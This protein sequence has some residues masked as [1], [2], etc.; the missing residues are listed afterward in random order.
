M[1]SPI[2]II[3]PTLVDQ[4]GH[5]HS[6]VGAVCAAG[7]EQ[8]LVVWAGRRASEV[9]TGLPHVT[10]R[11]HF[12]RR[13]RRVQAFLLYRKLLRQGARIF[14]P[15][16]GV[17]DIAL[18]CRAAPRRLAPGAAVAFCH[19]IRPT[20]RRKQRL[21]AAARRQPDL[22]VLAGADEIVAMLHDAGFHR[23]AYA[24]YP[25]TQ[26]APPLASAVPFRHLLFA[27]AARMDK[28]FPHIVD[29]A[30]H[31]A[32]TAESVP[33][34]VQTSA[35]HYGKLAP[36]IAAELLRLE[37]AAYRGLVTHPDTL[38]TDGYF[39]LFRGAICLQPYSREEFAGRVSAVTV[40]AL[41]C[42]AP[43]ITTRGTWMGRAIARR[44]A[45]VV[46]DDLSGASLYAAARE[47]IGGYHAFSERSR[48]AAEVIRREHDAV[49][50]LDA[51]R[52]P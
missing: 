31:L 24:P 41:A 34:C 51:V 5:C 38:D 27:G 32:R 43:I 12:S 28:G 25:L 13:L 39:A 26:A 9:L 49:H 15:T 22:R 2:H 1:S 8:S 45:G 21:A 33:L 20:K 40:D 16:A 35:K 7:P 29:L 17:T 47:I 19:W 18:L 11:R 30:L 14:V 36:D 4:T 23:A 48:K 44:G 42:G 10:L 52:A 3:E 6:F 46:L 37:R 50:L